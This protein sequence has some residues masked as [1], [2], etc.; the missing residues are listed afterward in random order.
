MSLQTGG[1]RILNMTDPEVQ[2]QKSMLSRLAVKS[3]QFYILRRVDN[4]KK[5]GPIR[6]EVP[7]SIQVDL[8]GS[9][10]WSQLPP[11]QA[12]A[13]K[14]FGIEGCLSSWLFFFHIRL[15]YMNND[16]K[17]SC[18]RTQNASS[19]RVQYSF[20][21]PITDFDHHLHV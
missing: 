6:F 14:L 13:K 18:N 8:L 19:Q 9:T 20:I 17:S 7:K 5:T 16:S 21:H 3:L 1:Y 11:L 4:A 15:Q 12:E 10:Y 2:R